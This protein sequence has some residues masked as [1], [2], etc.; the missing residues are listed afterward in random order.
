M[1]SIISA[2]LVLFLAAPAIA[3]LQVFACEP[4]W[5][6][7][8]ESLGGEHVNVYSATSA[9][10]DPHYIEARPSLIAKTRRADLMVCTGAELEIGWLPL[11]LRQSGNAA[12]QE[13]ELGYFLAASQVERIEI[14]DNL[15][16][17][18]GD[19]QASGNP[20]VH[21][22][23]YRL[24]TIAN[25][26]SQRLQQIDL[27]NKTSYQEKL[28]EFKNKWKPAITEWEQSMAHLK[29]KQVIVYHKNWSYLFRWLGVAVIADLEPKPGIPPT[30]SHLAGLLELARAEE[31]KGIV[32]ASYQN[33]KGAQWLS[34]KTT[35]PVLNLP[36]TVGGRK[37]AN[38]L[39]S[40]YN[41][42]LSDLGHALR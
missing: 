39:F 4:E 17:S 25:A 2:F 31:P 6:S 29:G 28:I 26:L 7:L 30:P 21:W 42:V 11:L 34:K 13:G 9:F 33:D 10:Q 41:M 23:P 8:V 40:L 12:I 37:E 22:D 19:V 35:I 14:P 1:K 36:Y 20:H 38:D 3:K 16:R 27:E 15:D 32:I 18:E 5:K 24:L